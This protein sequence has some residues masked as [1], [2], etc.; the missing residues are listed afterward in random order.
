M[1][2]NSKT[3]E[4]LWEWSCFNFD[5]DS[6]CQDSVSAEFSLS[7]DG[8]TLYYG[9]IFGRIFALGLGKSKGNFTVAPTAMHTVSPSVNPSS[10]PTQI[11][12][13][14]PSEEPT[15]L[16]TSIPS[17]FSSSKPST[18]PSNFPSSKPSSFPSEQ[19]SIYQ[20]SKPSVYS[21]TFP[22]LTPSS[23]PSEEPS[24]SIIPSSNPSDSPSISPS[25]IPSQEP[26]MY[27]GVLGLTSVS[28]REQVAFLG[29][30]SLSVL[31]SITAM[32]GVIHYKMTKQRHLKEMHEMRE[33]INIENEIIGK[34]I[35]V[36][37][38]STV[39]TSISNDSSEEGITSGVP[40]IKSNLP[41]LVEDQEEN[42]ETRQHGDGVSD[43]DECEEHD[44]AKLE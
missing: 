18:F 10:F 40:C 41:T 2:Q 36:E 42:C 13:A 30:A 29:M 19:P 8:F 26:S 1:A 31:F 3:G 20:S 28:P 39:V 44:E 37:E 33:G 11:P 35:C 17:D 7:P 14:T 23:F 21:S 5:R 25:D 15:I 34:E 22:S 12:S 16:P 32:I 4:I 27:Y 24:V 43:D 38:S 9:D 6:Y